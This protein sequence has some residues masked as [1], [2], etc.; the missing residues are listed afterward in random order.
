LGGELYLY[1]LKQH[2]QAAVRQL[3]HGEGFATDD[4]LSPKRGF[5]SFIRGRNL[6]VI[7]LASGK[8]LQLTR[9]GSTTIGNGVA[10]FV[11]DEEMDRHTGYWW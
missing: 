7:D 6:G 3:T 1:D 8:H 5:V 4:K 11:A 9:D 10:E 2:C